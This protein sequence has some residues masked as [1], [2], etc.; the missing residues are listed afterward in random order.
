MRFRI[1]FSY[2]IA[3]YHSSLQNCGRCLH[4][5]PRILGEGQNDRATGPFQP[6]AEILNGRAAMVRLQLLCIHHS[7]LKA[8][9]TNEGMRLQVGFFSLIIVETLLKRPLVPQLFG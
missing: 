1:L 3:G 2:S 4:R 5:I 9:L 6:N 8:P 7:F